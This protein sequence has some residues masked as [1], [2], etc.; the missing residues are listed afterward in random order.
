MAHT[1]LSHIV[2]QN[3]K[4]DKYLENDDQF[5]LTR[6]KLFPM[7]PALKLAKYIDHNDI[8]IIHFHWTKDIATVILAKVLSRKK[9]KVIQTRNMTMTKHINIVEA[10]F[11]LWSISF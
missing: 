1:L 10:I 7:I 6:N 4:L 2:E 11:I 8:D 9:P 3:T 5:Y